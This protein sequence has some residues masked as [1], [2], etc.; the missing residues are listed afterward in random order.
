V[1]QGRPERDKIEAER[2]AVE[3]A[4]RKEREAAEAK[5]RA[6]REVEEARQ[7]EIK[8]QQAELMDARALLASFRERFGHLAEFAGV[9]AAI[10]A[11]NQKKAA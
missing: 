3:E 8:R 9:V 6:E 1:K 7:R 2:R 5:A 11:M 4:Q 10:D